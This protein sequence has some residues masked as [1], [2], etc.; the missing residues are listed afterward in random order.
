MIINYVNLGLFV[1]IDEFFLINA[2]FVDL[3]LDVMLH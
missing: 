3:N 2:K 1:D